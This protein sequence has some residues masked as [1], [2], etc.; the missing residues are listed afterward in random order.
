MWRI[1]RTCY[2]A[3]RVLL[4]D[5]PDAEKPRYQDWWNELHRDLGLETERDI[6]ARSASVRALAAD[7]LGAA[8]DIARRHASPKVPP[9]ALP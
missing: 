7:V 4:A 6:R 5:A 9:T 2:P 3:C 8:M 1:H